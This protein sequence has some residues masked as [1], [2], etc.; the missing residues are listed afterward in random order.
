M[1]RRLGSGEVIRV[2]EQHGFY[3]V[4]QK[5]SH[6]KYKHANGRRTIVPHPK[7]NCRLEPH[8]QS[9]GSQG[10]LRP[11]SG[12]DGL[13]AAGLRTSSTMPPC[14]FVSFSCISRISRFKNLRSSAVI[15]G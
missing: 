13:S 1:P 11:I 15:C 14:L 4:S 9:F 7:R 5:G 8:A 6:C 12:S 10:C 2:L 3:F